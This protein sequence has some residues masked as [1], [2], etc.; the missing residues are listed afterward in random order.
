MKTTFIL[1]QHFNITPFEIMAQE[2]DAVI[3]VVNYLVDGG[4][5]SQLYP[6]LLDQLLKE[7]NS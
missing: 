1:A 4:M 2:I 3:M 7:K 6:R 5:T